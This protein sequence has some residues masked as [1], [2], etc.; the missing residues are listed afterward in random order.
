MRRVCVIGCSGAGKS[1][2]AVQMGEVFD[3]PVIHLDRY[4]WR[5]GWVPSPQEEWWAVQEEL[6]RREEWILDGNYTSSLHIRLPRADTVVFLDYPRS[7]CLRRAVK[8]ALLQWGWEVAPGCHE[9]LGR[10]HLEFLRY[11]WRLPDETRPRVV[12]AVE[13]YAR[14]ARVLRFESPPATRRW[15]ETKSRTKELLM[16]EAHGFTPDR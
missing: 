15:L 9:R 1:R 8:R 5:P 14:S 11:I 7:L 2:L 3:L 12:A 13:R 6:V 16:P 4:F 10:S